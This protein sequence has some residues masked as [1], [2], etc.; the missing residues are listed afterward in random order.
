MLERFRE[1]L[2]KDDVPGRRAIVIPPTAG[3][4]PGLLAARKPVG[5]GVAYVCEGTQCREP[6]RDPAAL[7]RILAQ[8]RRLPASTS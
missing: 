8:P 2:G 3:D 7:A 1:A 5:D 6:I 4:L